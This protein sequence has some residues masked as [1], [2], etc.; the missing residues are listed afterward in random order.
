MWLS[1]DFSFL[2]LLNVSLSFFQFCVYS[3]CSLFYTSYACL[4]CR[5]CC[6]IFMVLFALSVL[7]PLIFLF[8]QDL[9]VDA[10][11]CIHEWIKKKERNKELRA[12]LFLYAFLSIEIERSSVMAQRLCGKFSQVVCLFYIVLFFSILL[13][14]LILILF[15]LT[16]SFRPC[17]THSSNKR[18][19]S[20]NKHLYMQLKIWGERKYTFYSGANVLKRKYQILFLVE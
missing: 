17:T 20:L 2:C 5:C 11:K 14:H 6:W 9:Y 19:F 8:F 4:C 16:E 3:T 7:L 13:L 10:F 18:A 15:H 1:F 12:E